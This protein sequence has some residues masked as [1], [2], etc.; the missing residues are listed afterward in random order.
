M[1]GVPSYSSGPNTRLLHQMSILTAIMAFLFFAGSVTA[2]IVATDC[3]LPNTYNWVRNHDTCRRV[4]DESSSRHITRS[5]KIRARS[6]RT[7]NPHA[8][9]AVSVPLAFIGF[10]ASPPAAFTIDPLLPGETYIGPGG[11]DNDDMCKCNTIV[12]C[13]ISACD[14]CQGADWI[15]YDTSRLFY[16]L[17]FESAIS[18]PLWSLNCTSVSPPST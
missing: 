9:G 3:T 15:T 4:P 7:C 1:Q 10:S 6:P 12:Y 18:W 17:R 14:A 2:Q 13:L 11:A 16:I 8:A 5:I